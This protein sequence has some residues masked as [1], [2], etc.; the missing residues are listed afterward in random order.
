MLGHS[1]FDSVRGQTNKYAYGHIE[2]LGRERESAL[3]RITPLANIMA[4]QPLQANFLQ[5]T[6]CHFQGVSLDTE[7]DLWT[8][9][10][11]NNSNRLTEIESAPLTAEVEPESGAPSESPELRAQ[12]AELANIG[13][14]GLFALSP[15]RLCVFLASRNILRAPDKLKGIATHQKSAKEIWNILQHYAGN[16]RNIL[17]RYAGNSRDS[18]KFRIYACVYHWMY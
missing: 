1:E 11:L 14:S 9:L 18:P 16:S 5:I 4:Y 12:D 13:P 7:G 2:N 10:D 17:Q 8:L 15:T 3:L 6:E